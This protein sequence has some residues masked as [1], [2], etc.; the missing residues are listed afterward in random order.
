M[1]K[2]SNNFIAKLQLIEK[3]YYQNT[4]RE[5]LKEY[6]EYLSENIK[7]KENIKKL[8]LYLKNSKTKSTLIE[9]S[10]FDY[11]LLYCLQ[12]D[13]NKLLSESIYT[14]KLN[15]IISNID[16]DSHLYN[17]ILVKNLKNENILYENVAFLSPQEICPDKWEK[18]IKKK[19]QIEFKSQNVA[20]TDIY[21]CSKCKQKKCKVSQMQTRAA[22]EPMTTIVTCLVCFNTWRFSA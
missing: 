1:S 11:S 5:K 13:I 18:L 19:E 10:I 4:N 20:A 2:Y 3:T 22:D 9:R 6:N 17:P 14:N 12:K 16:K 8:K 7:R 21:K 15:E